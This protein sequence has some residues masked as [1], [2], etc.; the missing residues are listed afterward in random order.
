MRKL[1]TPERAAAPSPPGAAGGNHLLRRLPAGDLGRVLEACEGVELVVADVLYSPGERL[2]DVYFPV[3]GYLSL[4]MS[5][6]ETSA[7][8]VGQIGNE[9]MF[10]IPLGLG[11]D[12]APVHAVVQGGGSALRMNGLLFRRELVRSEALQ[13]EIGRYVCVCLAQLAQTSACT[14]FHLVEARLARCLLMTQDRSRASTFHVTHEKLA[15]MLGVRR[16][17]V[18]KAATA[19]QKRSLIHYNRGTV[20][21]LDRRGLKA[22]SCGCYQ[23]DRRSYDRLLG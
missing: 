2:R 17:G 14:R 12:V 20:T 10:G 23:A 8:E 18:T 4:I 9:G 7:L 22:A 3:S 19:L 21:V 15:L 11:V 6:D 16:V 1:P 5:V 13:R